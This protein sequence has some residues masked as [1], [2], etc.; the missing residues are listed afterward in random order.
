MAESAINSTPKPAPEPTYDPAHFAMLFASEDRHFWFRARNRILA[1]LAE[2]VTRKLP[3]GFRVLE[4]GCGTGNVLAALAQ[5]C[6]RGTVLGMDLF[7]EG[8]RFA[9]QRSGCQLLQGDMCQP[10]FAAQFDV[11]GMFD[12][13]EHLPDD[14]QVLRD[15]HR[16]LAPGGALLLTVP[17]HQSLWSAFDEAGHHCRRYELPDLETKLA[18]A[19]YTVEFLTEYMATIFPLVWLHRR[20]AGGGQARGASTH[21]Q[22]QKMIADELRITPGVNGVLTF[23]LFQEARWLARR[24]RLPFGTSLLAIARKQ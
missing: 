10:P 9:R 15:A 22:T 8:L 3:D 12:V 20:L 5:A 21:D 16:M 11:V 24:R 14:E 1:T 17:A 2:Q 4:V 13:L 18:R 19:G 6:R 23:L 7:A